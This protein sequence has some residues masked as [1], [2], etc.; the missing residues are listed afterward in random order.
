MITVT[1]QPATNITVLPGGSTA[2]TFASPQ[3]ITVTVAAAIVIGGGGGGESISINVGVDG[4]TV[5]PL[6][7]NPSMPSK[8]K[9]MINGVEYD[10]GSSYSLSNYQL[11]WLN[12]PFKLTT[13]DRI[14]LYY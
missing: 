12:D 1:P 3:A 4:Q 9:L 10:F 7:V 2:I 5:F 14:K 11:I 8:L 13:R 6:T